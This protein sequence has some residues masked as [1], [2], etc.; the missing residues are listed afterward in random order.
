MIAR[1]ADIS[2]TGPEPPD[3]ASAE[4]PMQ[5]QILLWQREILKRW[6]AGQEGSGAVDP[7]EI[8]QLGK[9]G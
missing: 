1:P 6:A 8:S 9:S 5:R 4:S 7:L 2:H 3:P